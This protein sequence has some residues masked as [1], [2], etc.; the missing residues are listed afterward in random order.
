[1][2]TAYVKENVH[3]SLKIAK[4]AA[5]GGQRKKV[6][7]FGTLYY[8]GMF[9]PTASGDVARPVLDLVVSPP[10]PLRAACLASLKVNE[11]TRVAKLWNG[12]EQAGLMD[13]F[14]VNIQFSASLAAG[15]DG[16][17]LWGG[18]SQPY[19]HT[20][21]CRA[22]L[23]AWIAAKLGPVSERLPLQCLCVCVCV[24]VCVC[25]RLSL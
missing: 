25:K 8:H 2:Q 24:C 5:V 23:M 13:D 19:L 18:G 21:E 7:P 20:D 11:S 4:L 6:L 12:Q 15:A 16:L 17:I 9:G 10:P 14:D 1:L 3:L 22:E